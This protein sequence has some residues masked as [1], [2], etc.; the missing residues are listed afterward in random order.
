MT[1]NDIRKLPDNNLAKIQNE[2]IL[3][4]N[5]PWKRLSEEFVRR[6]VTKLYSNF[7]PNTQQKTSQVYQDFAKYNTYNL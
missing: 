2:N 5:I 7:M 6:A 3:Y 1:M 4:F